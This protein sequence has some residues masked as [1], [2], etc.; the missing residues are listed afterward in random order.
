LERK[1]S[2]IR[3]LPETRAKSN[4]LDSYLVIDG[5]PESL[6]TTE[7][8][9]RGLNGNMPQKKLNL[10]QFSARAVFPLNTTVQDLVF[11]IPIAWNWNAAFQRALPWAMNLRVLT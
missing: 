2:I 8:F 4:L 6:L 1:S 10:L 3:R 7:I 11:K 9:F 5:F